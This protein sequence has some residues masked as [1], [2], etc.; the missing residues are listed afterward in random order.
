VGNQ[1]FF[2]DNLEVLRDQIADSSVDLVY[3]DPPFNSDAR[4]NV[5]FASPDD[6][7]ASAQAMAFRDTWT[8]DQEAEWAFSEVAR[9]GGSLASYVNAMHSALGRSDMMAYLVMMAVRLYELR[10][11]LKPTG[12]LYLHCDPTA[13]HYLKV[14]LDGIFGPGR[15]RN[16]II[17]HRTGA[18]SLSTRRLPSNHDVIL[19]YA[20]SDDS[21]W[22]LDAAC[23]PYDPEN[24]PAKT[25]QKY[26]HVDDAGRRFQL[27][28][29]LNPNKDRPNL[30]YEFLGVLRTWRWTR[31]R[32][33]AAY[34]AG[35]IHQSGP[36]RVPRLKRYLDEQRGAPLSDVWSDI[37]PL[38]SQAKERLGYPTQKPLS[39]LE[40]IIAL[41]TLPG[42]TVLDP[43]C[44]CG[45]TVH[46]AH[47]LDRQWIGVDVA[48]HA[49]EVMSERLERNLG[50]AEGR[51][52]SI[53]GRPNDIGSAVRLAERDKYQFQWWANY[54]VGVQQ[55]KEVRRGRDQGIDGE[56]FFPAGPGKGFGR[57]LTSVKGGNNVGVSDLRDFR[58]VLEREGAD[59]GLFIC[60][61][62]P[63]RD[64]RQNAASAGFFSIG[65][66]QYPRLQVVSI[67]EWFEDGARP[68]LPTMAHL[69]RRSGSPDKPARQ[70]RRPDPRQAE[71]LL[72]IGDI[73]SSGSKTHVN[74]RLLVPDD[75]ADLLT[76][77]I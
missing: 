69:A 64:M 46:A 52:Y 32:M 49:V 43:F 47:R 37:M 14:I 13:S 58:G 10:R 12:A 75:Q 53:S 34:D 48:Y 74:P 11:V 70:G 61:R 8:W 76:T 19:S 45:T 30:T 63:T 42:Q 59:A 62:R 72:P 33:Q 16:E 31:E 77:A 21:V 25:A 41:S 5:L 73:A 35:L 68:V 44:G 66:S 71:L 67:Q 65:S 40:R 7:K 1:L 38:N 6:K 20:M 51:D 56:M 18:K 9:L 60:L 39:L 15:L 17:W 28:N 57:I 54:L 23:L 4:Y 3:L 29:L 36:G 22:N 26:C 27:D 2:G 55:M 24:L 50:L